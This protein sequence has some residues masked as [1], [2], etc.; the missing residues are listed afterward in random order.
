MQRNL[1]KVENQLKAEGLGFRE[2]NTSNGEY[3][4][5]VTSHYKQEIARNGLI[6]RQ[7]R[8]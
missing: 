3:L 2:T 6:Q 8:P 5:G 4:G 1:L 7:E